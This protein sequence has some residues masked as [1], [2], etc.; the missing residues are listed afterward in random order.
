MLKFQKFGPQSLSSLGEYDLLQLGDMLISKKK[1]LEER[2]SLT[3]PFRVAEQAGKNSVGLSHGATGLRSL[4]LGKEARSTSQKSSEG[5]VDK[6]YLS[7]PHTGVSSPAIKNKHTERSRS[8]TF[9]DVQKLVSDIL[10]EHSDGYNMGLIPR[11]FLDKYGYPLDVQKLGYAKLAALLHVLPGVKVESTFIFPANHSAFTSD[12]EMS[13]LNTLANNSSSYAFDSDR[14]SSDS[15]PK[16]DHKDT[17][18][19]ELGPISVTNPEQSGLETKSRQEALNLETAIHPEYEPSLSDDD[20]SESEGDNYYLIRSEE[21]G[22]SKHNAEDSSL[23]QTL[24]SFYRSQEEDNVKSENTDTKSNGLTGGLHLSKHSTQEVLSKTQEKQ[25]RPHKSYSFVA[26]PESRKKDDLID[27]ILQN[28]R[29][30][31]EL[32]MRN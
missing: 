1:W 18:W 11:L 15:C 4:F 17:Q 5:D 3:F 12:I 23:L 14:E 25:Q 22:R 30:S 21:E 26:D 16:N 2:P 28:L 20:S 24:E 10:K 29:K 8:G 32:R 7:I 19:E 31:D 27:G 9:S 13:T 6:R